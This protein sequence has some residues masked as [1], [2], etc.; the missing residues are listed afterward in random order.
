MSA[1]DL[2]LIYNAYVADEKLKHGTKYERLA[3]IA[4]KALSRDDT[5]IHDLRLRGPGKRTKH[6]IDVTIERRGERRLR[7]IIECRHL[8]PQSKRPKIDL[9]AVRSFASVVRDLQPDQGLML[10]TVGYTEPAAT[11]AEDEGIALGIL[12][13]FH[14][15]DWD[16]RVQKVIVRAEL[17]APSDLHITSWLVKDD[18]ERERVKPLLEAQERKEW[19]SWAGANYFY[20]ENEEEADSYYDVFDPIYR[21]LQKHLEPGINEGV[22]EFDRVR[23]VLL[24][25]IMVGVRGFEWEIELEDFA[26]EFVIEIGDRVAKLLLQTLDGQLDFVIF[27]RD[28]MEFEVATDGEIVRR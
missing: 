7:L 2:D 27:D 14:D 24:G 28:L 5:V 9:D 23:R 10:T 13:P 12:R 20:D 18:A 15:E 16:E 11:Y 19:R 8:F 1:D 17:S 22:E 25:D 3:A 6:Q 4:F 21:R 26:H